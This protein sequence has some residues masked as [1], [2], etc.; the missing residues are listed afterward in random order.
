MFD[1]QRDMVQYRIIHQIIQS[2]REDN[3]VN[4]ILIVEDDENICDS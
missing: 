2:V 4:K 3:K 1:Y